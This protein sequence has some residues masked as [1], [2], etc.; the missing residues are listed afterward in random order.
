MLFSRIVAPDANAQVGKVPSARVLIGV[1]VVAL[2]VL[3]GLGVAVSKT[4][5][6]TAVPRVG[7]SVV[8]RITVPPDSNVPAGIKCAECGM[9]ES[10]RLMPRE[11]ETDPHAANLLNRSGLTGPTV[12]AVRMTEI[13]VRM[14]DGTSHQFVDA[15]RSKWHPGERMIF[16]EGM[17]TLRR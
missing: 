1:S 15:N 13:T 2:F 10:V 16:I 3:S 8:A 7:N 6:T 14:N 4:F 11:Q 17:K 5:A 12:A 9:I